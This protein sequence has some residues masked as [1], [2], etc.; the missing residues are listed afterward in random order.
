MAPTSSALASPPPT[1]A[2]PWAWQLSDPRNIP[3]LDWTERKAAPEAT[4]EGGGLRLVDGSLLVA[5][6]GRVP[7]T[8]VPH[9]DGD[10]EAPGPVR[11]AAAACRVAPPSPRR[12]P[13]SRGAASGAHQPG[14]R[15]AE[16]G[17]QI[18][19]QEEICAWAGPDPGVRSPKRALL[20]RAHMPRRRPQCAARRSGI[21]KRQR[22]QQ[23]RARQRCAGA[24]PPPHRQHRWAQSVREA[25]RRWPAAQPGAGSPGTD[26]ASPY[27]KLLA[28]GVPEQQVRLRMERDG[29]DPSLLEAAGGADAAQ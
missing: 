26:N 6:D 19:D 21:G 5:K 15:A 24:R 10:G 25:K 11:A 29:V 3:S 2:K 8:Y 9:S 23:R 20:T 14:G 13:S 18:L 1:A 22:Q 4:L 27:R 17:I 28:V 7:E 16:V 12:L